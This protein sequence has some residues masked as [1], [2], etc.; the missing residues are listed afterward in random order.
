MLLLQ[1][2][3]NSNSQFDVLLFWK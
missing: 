2:K 1:A 3:V